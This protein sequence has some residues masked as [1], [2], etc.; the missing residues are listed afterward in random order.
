MLLPQPVRDALE[1]IAARERRQG[2]AQTL[3]L[4]R[5]SWPDEE[6]ER[7]QQNHE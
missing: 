3:R 6:E 5:D 1:G 7:N 4:M 2:F